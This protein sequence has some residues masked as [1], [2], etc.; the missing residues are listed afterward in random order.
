MHA[1][2][3][4]QLIAALP[5]P[6]NLHGLCSHLLPGCLAS[7]SQVISLGD[8]CVGKSCLIKRYCEKK[9]VSKYISTIGVDF[10]VRQVMADSGVET[11]VNF[12]SAAQH[13]PGESE[14]SEAQCSK[15]KRRIGMRT[16]CAAILLS[17]C[18][19]PISA[20]CRDLAGGPEMVEVRREFH[21]EAQ[22]VMLVYDVGDLGSFQALD[23]WMGEHSSQGG[24][25]LVVV[26]CA[27]KADG[28]GPAEGSPQVK[29]LVSEAEG[30]KSAQ[31]NGFMYMETSAKSGL[32]VDHMFAAMFKAI[33]DKTP[34]G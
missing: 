12:W 31:A 27:N 4:E 10:G 17:L 26:V 1:R 21:R 6:S 9:F 30:K 11:K 2:E 3:E 24:R 32:N 23:R 34:K 8:A 7:A 28:S 16:H 29:R 33:S 25:P 5:P 14:A 18:C 19:A 22:G 15:K 20:A 13:E